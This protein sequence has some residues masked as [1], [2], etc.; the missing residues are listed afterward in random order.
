MISALEQS[1]T[2]TCRDNTIFKEFA[3][4]GDLPLYAYII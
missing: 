1:K 2:C 3:M 4:D